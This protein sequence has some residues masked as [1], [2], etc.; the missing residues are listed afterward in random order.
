MDSD[1]AKFMFFAFAL[2]TFLVMFVYSVFALILF[3]LSPRETMKYIMMAHVSSMSVV[4]IVFIMAW[5]LAK[6]KE[7]ARE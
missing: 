1:F 2:T 5:E 6:M 7:Q 3:P 4:A